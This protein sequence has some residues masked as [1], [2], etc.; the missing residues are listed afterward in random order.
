MMY[1]QNER[2]GEEVNHPGRRQEHSGSHNSHPLLSQLIIPDSAE[3]GTRNL[4]VPQFLFPYRNARTW[5]IWIYDTPTTGGKSQKRP[6]NPKTGRF[7]QW[8]DPTNWLTLDEA[9]VFLASRRSNDWHLGIVL[10]EGSSLTCGDLDSC[11]NPETGELTSIAQDFVTRMLAPVEV[12]AS[13]TGIHVWFTACIPDPYASVPPYEI[14]QRRPGQKLRFIGLT[15]DFLPDFPATDLLPDRTVEVQDYIHQKPPLSIT[16]PTVERYVSDLT[17]EQVLAQIEDDALASRRFHD[18]ADQTGADEDKSALDMS[19]LYLLGDYSIDWRQCE[20]IMD[21]TMLGQNGRWVEKPTYRETTLESLRQYKAN[22][23]DIL[24]RQRK[25]KASGDE[26]RFR[27]LTLREALE[28]KPPEYIIGEYVPEDAIGMLYGESGKGKSFLC[29]DMAMHV[30][31]GRDWHGHKVKQ[32]TVVYLAAEGGGGFSKRLAAWVSHHGLSDEVIDSAPIRPIYDVASFIEPKESALFIDALGTLAEPP[33][34]MFL[35]TLSW[36]MAGGDE[37]SAR[38]TSRALETA[39]QIKERYGT[40]CIFIHHTGHDGK[41]PRGSSVLKG[42]LDVRFKIVPMKPDGRFKFVVEKQKDDAEAAPKVFERVTV[43]LPGLLA[44]G[45]DGIKRRVTSCIVE[46]LDTVPSTFE[47]SVIQHDEKETAILEALKSFGA[48]GA[49]DSQIKKAAEGC[50][51][52]GPA[53]I[54]AREVL[55]DMGK[56]IPEPW[57][58]DKKTTRGRRYWHADF[59]PNDL[60]HFSELSESDFIDES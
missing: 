25:Q 56:V 42:N 6:I 26:R 12:S 39:K 17:D 28:V 15:G 45:G 44:T 43:S 20:R 30:A 33:T 38:D 16:G 8:S 2:P 51:T 47:D 46:L 10:P 57:P 5:L 36:L 21:S 11:R 49:T 32:G 37:N 27:F 9:L 29:L 24:Y 35:D 41:G 4:A 22:D 31:L 50:S 1:K 14:Y 48:D 23:W 58:E 60:T 13:G 54:G 34:L 7:S 3:I 59:A 19:L 55:V 40:T 52:G 53:Y 18:L